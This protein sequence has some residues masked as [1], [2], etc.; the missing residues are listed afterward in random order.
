MNVGFDGPQELLR[1]ATR[2]FPDEGHP[3]GALRPMLEKPSGFD[4][5]HWREEAA[6]DWT[7]RLIPPQHE[8]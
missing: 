4:R 2:R 7:L 5:D 3:I 8:R 1:S 6:L